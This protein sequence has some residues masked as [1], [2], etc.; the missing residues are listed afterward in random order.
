MT[1]TSAGTQIKKYWFLDLLRG[2][3]A[4]WVFLTH[5]SGHGENKSLFDLNLK[6]L[7]DLLH[8][9][10]IRGFTH[11]GVLIFIVLSGFV[12]NLNYKNQS[13]KFGFVLNRFWRLFPIFLTGAV[14]GYATFFLEKNYWPPLQNIFSDLSFLGGLNFSVVSGHNSILSTV[15]S[16]F[17]LYVSYFLAS[18]LIGIK[19]KQ[20]LWALI[21]AAAFYSLGSIWLINANDYNLW[22]ARF[23]SFVIFLLP[24]WLGVMA[25][26]LIQKD[27][28]KKFALPVLLVATAGL[29][30]LPVYQ[31]VDSN[32]KMV[33]LWLCNQLYYSL[34]FCLLINYSI[35]VEERSLKVEKIFKKFSGLGAIS[36]S[37]YAVHMPIIIL[38]E[39]H[40][41]GNYSKMIA[42]FVVFLVATI[43]HYFVEKPLMRL[44]RAKNS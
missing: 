28:S 39:K 37:L 31:S 33:A 43:C 21:F 9:S 41:V 14:L 34:Y 3:A 30:L 15:H 5:L 27:I 25:S 4:L 40:I 23:P 19:T 10:F 18:C 13:L 44:K 1:S 12:I 42:M 11:T 20:H 16:E 6:W 7:I 29:F 17:F 26:D 35:A 36:Y 24:W 8:D 32:S 2:F 22:L 38:A